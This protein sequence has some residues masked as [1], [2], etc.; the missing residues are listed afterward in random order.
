MRLLGRLGLAFL[1]VSVVLL[2]RAA[3]QEA[4]E[5]SPYA[6]VLAAINLEAPAGWLGDDAGNLAPAAGPATSSASALDAKTSPADGV[7]DTA[8]HLR[9]LIALEG[10]LNTLDAYSYDFSPAPS[11]APSPVPKGWGGEEGSGMGNRKEMGG[12]NRPSP[13]LADHSALA[14]CRCCQAWNAR[15]TG[16]WTFSMRLRRTL[17]GA[18]VG[19][20]VGAVVGA[21]EV[22]AFIVGTPVAV[23]AIVGA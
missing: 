13:R 18:C 8:A 12:N 19:S 5:A 4:P 23:G 6:D 14:K 1:S 16:P 20:A 7:V 9:A 11:G 22:V 2:E 3:A 17:I 21:S 15:V 10:Q